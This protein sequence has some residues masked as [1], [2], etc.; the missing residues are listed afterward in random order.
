[1]LKDPLCIPPTLTVGDVVTL[2]RQRGFS[3][4]P[5][6]ENGRVVGIV[7]NRDIRFET[8]MGQPASAVMTPRARLVTVREGAGLDAARELMRRHRISRVVVLG[9]TTN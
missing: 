6:V 1:V 9:P 4:L 7:T 8:D 2:V 3:S 5:V